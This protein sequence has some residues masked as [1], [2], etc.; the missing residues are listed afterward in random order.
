V[1]GGVVKSACTYANGGEGDLT[2]EG[3][4]YFEVTIDAGAPRK[5]RSGLLWC[6][7]AA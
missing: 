5:A 2:R 4:Y 6:T 3:E 1:S 7:D